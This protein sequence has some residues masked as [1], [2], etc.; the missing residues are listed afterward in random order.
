[1]RRCSAHCLQH[2]SADPAH[3]LRAYEWQRRSR[4]ARAQREARR[5]S[6]RYHLGGPLGWTRNRVLAG[7]GGERMLHRYDWIY[8]LASGRMTHVSHSAQIV[9]QVLQSVWS[10]YTRRMDQGPLT[11]RIVAAFDAMPAQLQTAARYVLDRPS[12][13]ALLSMREQARQAGCSPPP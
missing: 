7:L 9:K 1:M 4:V 11:V 12:D 10:R 8:R 3:A 6:W 5:N 13:V 2:E